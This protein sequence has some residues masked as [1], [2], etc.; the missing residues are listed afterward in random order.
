MKDGIQEKLRDNNKKVLLYLFRMIIQVDIF[1][2]LEGIVYEL[3][4]KCE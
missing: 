3:L 1:E 2:K 4:K